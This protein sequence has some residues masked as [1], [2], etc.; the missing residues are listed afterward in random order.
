MDDSFSMEEIL[1]EN[2]VA[3]AAVIQDAGLSLSCPTAGDG[4]NKFIP[5]HTFDN[6]MTC[7]HN[8]GLGI[9]LVSN[10]NILNA[11]FRPMICFRML[12]FG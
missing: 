3:G 4:P 6:L 7:M 1:D 12:H 9:D 11:N 2:N 5:L 10:K 8:Y